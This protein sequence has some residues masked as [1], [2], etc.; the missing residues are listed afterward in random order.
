MEDENDGGFLKLTKTQEWVSGDNVAPV[1][2]K[3]AVKELQNNSEKRKKLSL[4]R[5]DALKRELLLLTTTIGAACSGYCLTTLSIQ[6]AVSYAAGVLFSCLYLQL[7]YRYADNISRERVPQIFI[8]KKSKKIG[9]RSD[10]LKDAFERTVKGSTFALSSPRLVIPGAI[11]GL[12]G[13]SHHFFNSSLDFQLV[14]AM[15]GMFA[16]K[17]AALV[18]VYRDNEDL[19]LIFPENEESPNN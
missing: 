18:Q 8:Q 17:A 2:R 15:L 3:M 11:Y 4:L 14:P 9:I 19:L 13:L 6:A 5:Y 10:D 16:Y 12:W 1:N 7:L